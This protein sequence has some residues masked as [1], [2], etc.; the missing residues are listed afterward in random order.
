M[1]NT[2]S[3]VSVSWVAFTLQGSEDRK[4]YIYDAHSAAVIKT[5]RGHPSVVHLVAKNA[6]HPLTF[7]SSSI[8]SVSSVA[9][10]LMEFRAKYCFG[11]LR[12][13]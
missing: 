8:E 13:M 3:Q 5:L 10:R 6:Q 4:V 2:S 9:V 11:D 12:M 1:R 7:A